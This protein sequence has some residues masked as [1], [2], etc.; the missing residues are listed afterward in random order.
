MIDDKILTV[1]TSCKTDAHFKGAV[2]YIKLALKSNL[3]GEKK[4][5][6]MV[7]VIATLRGVRKNVK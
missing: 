4:F 5:Y 6:M 2:K 7:G 1:I 3:I